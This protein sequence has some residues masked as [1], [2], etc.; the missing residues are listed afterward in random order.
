[1]TNRFVKSSIHFHVICNP[2]FNKLY[3]FILLCFTLYN[4][5]HFSIFFIFYNHLFIDVYA[6]NSWCVRLSRLRGE[7]DRVPA[8]LHIPLPEKHREAAAELT[9]FYTRLLILFLQPL[10]RSLG[11]APSKRSSHLTAAARSFL[12]DFTIFILYLIYK[13]QIFCAS[14]ASARASLR[15]AAFSFSITAWKEK[16]SSLMTGA[17]TRMEIRFGIAM[18]AFAISERF[19]TRSRV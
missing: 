8:C 6:R 5:C 3:D 4:F 10:I 9:L 19:Q 12:R 7:S 2:M 1:M 15:A 17:R 18:R 14:S 13:H 16:T 11:R